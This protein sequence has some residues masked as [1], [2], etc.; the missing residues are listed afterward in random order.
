MPETTDT[1]KARLTP[2]EFV[3]RKEAV[4]MIG[5]PFLHKIN[6]LPKEGGHSAIDKIKH[7]AMLENMKS[8]YGGGQVQMGYEN[9]G[10]VGADATATDRMN[11]LLAAEQIS[12]LHTGGNLYNTSEHDP[13]RAIS[14]GAFMP[15]AGVMSGL[16]LKRLPAYKG[17]ALGKGNE[18][19]IKE[20]EE[21]LKRTRKPGAGLKKKLISEIDEAGL[22]DAYGEPMSYFKDL[23]TDDLADMLKEYYGKELYQ[24]NRGL[25]N[26]LKA[27]GYQSG[28]LTGYQPGGEVGLLEKILS[29]LSNI[30]A[31]KGYATSGADVSPYTMSKRELAEMPKKK[32]VLY[33][34]QIHKNLSDAITAGNIDKIDYSLLT[35]PFYRPHL[36]KTNP[37]YLKEVSW[38]GESGYQSGGLAS[39]QPGGEVQEKTLYGAGADF[40]QSAMTVDDGLYNT[41]NVLSIPAEQVGEGSGLRYYGG[42]GRSPH[43]TLSRS[44]AAMDARK[45]MN[46]APQDS[47]PFDMIEQ[48]LAPEEE[49]PQRRGLRGLLGFQTGGSVNVT[50]PTN[51]P[52]DYIV[53]QG[54]TVGKGDKW[55]KRSIF[56][57]PTDDGSRYYLGEAKS[58]R[59][60]NLSMGGEKM[61]MLLDAYNTMQAT[62]QDSI[63]SA[64]VEGY[65]DEKGIRGLLGKFGFQTGGPVP[66]GP[67]APR[68]PNEIMQP[69]Q[70]P[71]GSV[72]GPSDADIDQLRM[73]KAE[74][75]QKSIQQDT[76]SKARN[77][78]DLIQLLDSLKQ[79]GS[80]EAIESEG[81]NPQPYLD[82]KP[83][84]RDAVKPS[85]G[86][87]IR[88][89]F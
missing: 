58:D 23:H 18:R 3:V 76:V 49:Q 64:N 28:G 22:P 15:V 83:F 29:G 41:R 40:N 82:Q 59:R 9:G 44:L 8:M 84:I 32:K 81:L 24:A 33:R 85:M 34:D 67:P 89:M 37:G 55:S 46:I 86:Q 30:E 12:K 74:M 88:G 45:Q 16:G 20:A 68:Q 63:P 79:S 56:N 4:D 2:G 51:D 19:A 6:N 73:M 50:L 35:D 11:Q 21:L 5:L 60:A 17:T 26:T 57:L 54:P 53:N 7:M 36:E 70:T 42:E 27:S 10:S 78:L 43:G 75:L 87:M 39:Y 61:K 48:Y 47:I 80:S 31:Y 52:N 69:G 66:V 13:V 77:T 62:P 71:A 1:I 72:M 25:F 38:G 65:F 14:E